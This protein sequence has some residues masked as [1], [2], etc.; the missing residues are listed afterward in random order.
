MRLM[1][2]HRV[3]LKDVDER[4]ENDGHDEECKHENRHDNHHEEEDQ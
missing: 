1:E 2:M 4:H 3:D